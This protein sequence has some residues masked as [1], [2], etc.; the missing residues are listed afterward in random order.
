MSIFDDCDMCVGECGKCE[1]ASVPYKVGF[2]DGEKIGQAAT[3]VL[4]Y[5][6]FKAKFLEKMRNITDMQDTLHEWLPI[7]MIQ[8]ADEVLYE[9]LEKYQLEDGELE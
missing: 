2:L 6:E 8:F 7:H 1:K 3:S 5:E 9:I 4:I